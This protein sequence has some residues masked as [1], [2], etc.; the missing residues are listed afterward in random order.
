M[1]VSKHDQV[2]MLN[3]FMDD[4]LRLSARPT[5]PLR[6][7]CNRR[8]TNPFIIRKIGQNHHHGYPR[9]AEGGARHNRVHE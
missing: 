9:A 1:L 4:A 5:D 3:Q 2:A 8:P 6:D 7:G